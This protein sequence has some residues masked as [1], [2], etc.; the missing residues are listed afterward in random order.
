[1]SGGFNP[2]N[3]ASQVALGVAT[4]GSSIAL[5][6]AVQ[7]GQQVVR[8]AIQEVAQQIGLPPMMTNMA[9]AAFDG[10]T[11]NYGQALQDGQ[12]SIQSQLSDL[13]S[14]TGANSTQMGEIQNQ[15]D[16]LGDI[17]RQLVLSQAQDAA[18]SSTDEDGNRGSARSKAHSGGGE[19]W[20]QVLAEVLGNKL[21][22]A[23]EQFKADADALDWK[24]PAEATKFTAETQ[25]LGMLF[26]S[27]SSAIK[28][29]GEGEKALAT[30]Q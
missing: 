19:S 20:L 21:S 1:M 10:A 3:L 27:I 16:D 9:L 29:I 8:S 5:Q 7:V 26:Q 15:L 2:I 6:L 22:Q 30:R 23:S 25:E 11:G 14:A 28:S 13:Q 12:A 24:D 17:T 4:G 18:Q